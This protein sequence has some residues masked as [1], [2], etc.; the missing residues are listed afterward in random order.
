MSGAPHERLPVSHSAHRDETTIRRALVT[1]ASAGLGEEFAR[2]LGARGTD[3]VLVARREDRLEALAAHLRA[4]GRDVEVLVADL[5][6]DE[7]QSRVEARLQDTAQ[8]VD[9]L[10]N[11]AGFG[12]YGDVADLSVETQLR[13]VEV[14]VLAV[15]RLARAALPGM[16]ARR[17]GGVIN[18]ASTAAFQPN[19]HAA[20]YGATKAYVL[21][22]SQALHE[23]VAGDGVR[24]LALCPGVTP[25]EFQEVADIAVPLPD[26]VLTSPAQVVAA[27][28]RAFARRRAVEVPGLANRVA[29]AA[30]S[31]GPA[32]LSRRISGFAHRTFTGTR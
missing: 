15:T 14:N 12:A 25:T 11:N 32:V 7:G 21:S 13:M 5:A 8:P 29:A 2:Q 27:G 4:G 9:L 6:T 26:A 31:T 16:T 30:S 18:L 24:V 3:L 28:L 10:V 17:R 23:E 22:L 19:P 20:V 1:G